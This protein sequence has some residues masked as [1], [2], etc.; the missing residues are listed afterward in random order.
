MAFAGYLIKL[1]SSSGSELPMSFMKAESY[2]VEPNK[3]LE[4]GNQQAVTGLTR[5]TTLE[6]T[7]SRIEFDTPILTN[8]QL[9]QLTTLLQNNMSSTARRDITIYYYD[10]E[11]DSYRVANCYMPDIK[12]TIRRI[13][14]TKI[15]YKPVHIT[16]IEY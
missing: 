16:F 15:S 11:T 8:V 14:G 3:R 2:N 9:A 13:E 10:M 7:P 12:Y 4:A 1:G 6:H 5:R